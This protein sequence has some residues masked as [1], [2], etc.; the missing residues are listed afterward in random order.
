VL[1]GRL[2]VPATATCF[3]A[4]TFAQT[5]FGSTKM[6]NQA[7][8]RP[9]RLSPIE[10]AAV[11][12]YIGRL[13][14][15][16]PAAAAAALAPGG[17]TLGPTAA[18]AALPSPGHLS[19]MRPTAA[20][21]SPNDPRIGALQLQEWLLLQQHQQQQISRLCCHEMLSNV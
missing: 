8:Q 16:G 21:L 10:A 3:T 2:P 4:A 5:K 19:P 9:S 18:A 1:P 7:P 12:G 6:K 11:S 20:A 17:W 14:P 15:T 13:S